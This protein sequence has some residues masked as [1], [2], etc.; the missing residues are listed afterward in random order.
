MGST[1]SEIFA[2][3]RVERREI[4]RTLSTHFKHVRLG[5]VVIFGGFGEK[6]GHFSPKLLLGAGGE[7]GRAI[8]HPDGFDKI[9]CTLL[10]LHAST[11]VTV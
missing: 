6:T 2:W 8:V 3:A 9:F 4:G 11:T 10:G 5:D 7:T 1:P